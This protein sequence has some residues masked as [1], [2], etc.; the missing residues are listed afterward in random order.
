MQDRKDWYMLL[1]KDTV[2]TDKEY[3]K[4]ETDDD[5][6][7]AD[8]AVSMDAV[9]HDHVP[10]LTSQN[11]K[12]QKILVTIIPVTGMTTVFWFWCHITTLKYVKINEWMFNDTSAQK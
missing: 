1:W 5:P 9:V 8:T 10:V 11:L 6:Q 7:I 3:Y 4:I 12:T 2:T